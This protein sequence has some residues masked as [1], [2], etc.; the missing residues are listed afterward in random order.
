MGAGDSRESEAHPAGTKELLQVQ[1]GSVSI[2][3]GGE[4]F[5][6]DTGDA[7]SLPGDV[8]TRTAPWARNRLGSPWQ[9]LNRASV[10]DTGQRRPMRD[11]D[12]LQEFLG[13]AWV[14]T[15]VFALRPDYQ[16]CSSST[17]SKPIPRRKLTCA[18]Q[19]ES[20]G[21]LG[22]SSLPPSRVLVHRWRILEQGSSFSAS[23]KSGRRSLV[24]MLTGEPEGHGITKGTVK[25]SHGGFP[26]GGGLLVQASIGCRARERA[27]AGG[28]FPAWLLKERRRRLLVT[29]KTLEKAIAAPAS[30]GLSKP[31]AANGIAA[32]L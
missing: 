5:V 25:E 3:V 23:C 18:H 32:T 6:L 30:I 26:F 9:F 28:G 21:P 17:H 31:R 2:V 16:R 12:A 11:F 24:P 15:A 7:V 1:D 19:E 22:A 4:T 29:T 13:D 27:P 8:N 20:I 10:Q 14:D